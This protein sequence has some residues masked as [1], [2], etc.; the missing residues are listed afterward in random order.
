MCVRWKSIDGIHIAQGIYTLKIT[1]VY[2]VVFE[3]VWR[4][5]SNAIMMTQHVL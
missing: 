4:R 5:E 1:H 2:A 3:R